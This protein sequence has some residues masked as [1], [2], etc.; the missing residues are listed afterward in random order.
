MLLDLVDDTSPYRGVTGAVFGEDRHAIDEASER[1]RHAG[2]NVYVNDK[3][4]RAVVGAAAVPR[5][6]A[7][8]QQRQGG[9]TLN[10]VRCVSA[11]AIKA[12]VPQSD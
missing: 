4:T 2:G 3:P 8:R 10:L 12:F 6:A 7:V 5:G 11:R 9:S 1:V